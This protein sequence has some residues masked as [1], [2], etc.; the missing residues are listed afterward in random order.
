[1][2]CATPSLADPTETVQD[3]TAHSGARPFSCR[4]GCEDCAYQIRWLESELALSVDASLVGR[5]RKVFPDVIGDQPFALA[6]MLHRAGDR[7]LSRSQLEERLPEERGH[8][9]VSTR[10]VDTQLSRLRRALGE[11]CIENV[12]HRGWRLTPAGHAKIAAALMPK[13]CEAA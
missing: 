10:I 8:E 5:L 11:G 7:V 4:C 1:M 3:N 9:R 2:K 13:L 6:L 12:W